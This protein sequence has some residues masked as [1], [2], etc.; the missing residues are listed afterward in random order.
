MAFFSAR[1]FFT[2]ALF[3]AV[4]SVVALVAAASVVVVPAAIS[5]GTYMYFPSTCQ[6]TLFPLPCICPEKEK[7]VHSISLSPETKNNI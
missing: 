7:N 6:L 2:A 1:F 3:V 5:C 4:Q